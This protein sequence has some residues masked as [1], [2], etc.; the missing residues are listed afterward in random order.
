MLFWC[1]C[2]FMD[3]ILFLNTQGLEIKRSCVVGYHITHREK[4][5][6]YAG[7]L[8]HTYSVSM[9]L[10]FQKESCVKP[11]YQAWSWPREKCKC[12]MAKELSHNTLQISK[13]SVQAFLLQ[14][15]LA[16]NMVVFEQHVFS[17]TTSLGGREELLAPFYG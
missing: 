4:T 14:F 3:R 16:P 5:F 13:R 8:W 2:T 6:L 17:L 1:C 12:I 10:T 15:Y 11:G 7:F 9:S